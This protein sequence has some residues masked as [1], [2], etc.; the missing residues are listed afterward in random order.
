M[1]IKVQSIAPLTPATIIHCTPWED[2]VSMLILFIVDKP[3]NPPIAK[4]FLLTSAASSWVGKRMKRDDK[5][6][7]ARDTILT[8]LETVGCDTSNTSPTRSW[9]EPVAK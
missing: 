6:A 7:M 1:C 3:G 4:N 9:K 8:M 5:L 2:I